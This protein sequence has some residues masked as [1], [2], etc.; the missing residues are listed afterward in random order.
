MHGIWERPVEGYTVVDKLWVQ[1]AAKK[2]QA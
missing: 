2:E 1:S